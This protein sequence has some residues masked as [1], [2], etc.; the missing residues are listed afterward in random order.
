MTDKTKEDNFMILAGQFFMRKQ[1]I[2]GVD[3]T[4]VLGVIPQNLITTT[5]EL[6]G[7]EVSADELWVMEFVPVLVKKYKVP[8]RFLG[9]RAEQI[10]C[11]GP[12]IS[13]C[14]EI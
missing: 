10:L 1:Q 9:W 7:K 12:K 11:D 13:E 4:M 3:I 5:Q 6:M 14:E 8:G 2:N